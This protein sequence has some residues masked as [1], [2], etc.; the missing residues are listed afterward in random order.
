MHY[1]LYQLYSTKSCFLLLTSTYTIGQYCS[2]S[3]VQIPAR[4]GQNHF[5]LFLLI[6]NSL[7]KTTEYY[8]AKPFFIIFAGYKEIK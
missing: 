8:I 5:V 3:R 7:L 2:E 6:K 1:W 4:E